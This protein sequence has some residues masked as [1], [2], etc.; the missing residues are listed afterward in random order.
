MYII[1]KNGLLITVTDL[2]GAIKQ[3]EL[4]ASYFH[5]DKAFAD[6]DERQKEYWL[7]VLLQLTRLKNEQPG[8]VKH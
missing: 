2:D 5:E 1:D 3:A 8:N 7:D 6:F 4:F